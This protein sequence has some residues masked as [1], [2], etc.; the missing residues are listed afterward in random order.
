MKRGLLIAGL[1]IAL[2]A[3]NT[4]C[5]KYEEGPG[6]SLRSKTAR[7]AGEWVVDKYVDKDGNESEDQFNSSGIYGK[8]GSLEIFIDGTSLAKGTWEFGDK[9]ETIITDLGSVFGKDT[10][11]IVRLAHKEFWTADEDG[12]QTRLKPKE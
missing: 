4:A 2:M 6:I 1:A 11:T 10:A 7:V 8:D 5:N 9:K 3:G 12:N